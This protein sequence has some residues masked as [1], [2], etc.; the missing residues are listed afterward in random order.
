MA[1]PYSMIGY[2]AGAGSRDPFLEADVTTDSAKE[3][4]TGHGLERFLLLPHRPPYQHR[5]YIRRGQ[6]HYEQMD[7]RLF[8]FSHLLTPG[9]DRTPTAAEARAGRWLRG[10]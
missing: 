1:G 9:N 5:A 10:G 4:A 8:V 6:G 2:R 7:T 3:H